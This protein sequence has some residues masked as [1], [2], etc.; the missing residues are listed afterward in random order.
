MTYDCFRGPRSHFFLTH[1]SLKSICYLAKCS[2]DMLITT[3]SRRPYLCVIR[4]G[5][6]ICKLWRYLPRLF[7]SVPSSTSSSGSGRVCGGDSVKPST[8]PTASK[9][10]ENI[11]VSNKQKQ[12]NTQQCSKG[13]TILPVTRDELLSTLMTATTGN[14]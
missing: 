12:K 1:F 2:F 11:P 3:I 6:S 8:C 9:A 10:S 7:V 4:K 13:Y 14:V 5:L